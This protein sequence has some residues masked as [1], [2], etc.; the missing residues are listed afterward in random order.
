MNWVFLDEDLEQM[1]AALQGSKSEKDPEAEVRYM[2]S[3][4]WASQLSL[5]PFVREQNISDLFC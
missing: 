3:W 4:P 1:D 2:T 5:C